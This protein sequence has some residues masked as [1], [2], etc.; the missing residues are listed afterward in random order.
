MKKSAP[1][2]YTR[3]GHE[4]PLMIHFFGVRRDPAKIDFSGPERA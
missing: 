2:E 4:V 1:L 3:T